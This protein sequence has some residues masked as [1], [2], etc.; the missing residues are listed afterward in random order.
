MTAEYDEA[1][2]P[3]MKIMKSLGWIMGIVFL[4]VTV[5]AIYLSYTTSWDPYNTVIR[6]SRCR[7]NLKNI[8]TALEMYSADNAGLY[9]ASLSKLTPDYL[10]KIPGCEKTGH[11]TG[12]PVYPYY[13]LGGKW[14]NCRD[15]YSSSYTVN[16]KAQIYTMFCLGANHV[17]A[18]SANY[19]RYSSIEGLMEKP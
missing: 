5:Y 14:V 12:I 15:N 13:K 18:T 6:G 10:K 8:G 2:H 1:E 11:F 4:G 3:I 9:P 16:M 7:S 19:P 17:P